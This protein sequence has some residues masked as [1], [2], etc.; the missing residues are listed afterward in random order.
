MVTGMILSWLVLSLAV[1]VAATVLDGVRIDGVSSIVVVAALFGVLNT[2]LG[3]FFFTVISIATLG[4]GLLLA[5]LTRWVVDA[6]ILTLV[7]K[8]TDRIHIESFGTAFLAA[9]IMAFVGS[10]GQGALKLMG[11][12]V[13]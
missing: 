2:L 4:I 1:W 7:D 13:A 3:W 11:V 10:V 6:I 5:F 12:G 9:L 8:V